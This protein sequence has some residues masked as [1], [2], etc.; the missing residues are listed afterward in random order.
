MRVRCKC[1]YEGILSRP[2]KRKRCR[3]CGADLR[4]GEPVKPRTVKLKHPARPAKRKRTKPKHEKTVETPEADSPE[5]T[6]EASPQS[7]AE[8]TTPAD[9]T[10]AAGTDTEETAETPEAN[11][12][13]P[14]PSETA[15]G[16][17]GQK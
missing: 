2:G 12:P 6:P 1:G 5:Q 8:E 3:K 15:V 10:A 14:G 16:N 13:E 4:D 9:E 17:N 7:G 11:S